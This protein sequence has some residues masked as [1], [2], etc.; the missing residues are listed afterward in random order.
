MSVGLFIAIFVI[1]VGSTAFFIIRD[2]MS[3]AVSPPSPLIDL[4]RMYDVIYTRLDEH[5]GSGLTPE[6]LALI[7]R[8]FV[9]CLG[10]HHLI[11]ENILGDKGLSAV[12]TLDVESVV[13]DI[14]SHHE[15][16]VEDGVIA[17][18]VELSFSY[19]SDISAVT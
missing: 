2:A 11:G 15:I 19:L 17:H 18:V 1:A 10:R 4:D 13:S 14:Q 16:D 12:D 5:Y 9:D 7:L 8:G 3:F 6:D